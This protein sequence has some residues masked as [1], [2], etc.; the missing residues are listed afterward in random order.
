VRTF[1]GTGM[2]AAALVVGL[3]LTFPATTADAS[4]TGSSW[5]H[6][7]PGL[8][9][10]T[11][12]DAT[13]EAEVPQEGQTTSG[14]RATHSSGNYFMLARFGVPGGGRLEPGQYADGSIWVFD[15]VFADSGST[16]VVHEVSYGPDGA[17]TVLALDY[18]LDRFADDGVTLIRKVFG[19][20]RFHSDFQVGALA[21]DGLK[22]FG[23]VVTTVPAQRTI[24]IEN[25]G[26]RPVTPSG[27]RLDGSRATEFHIEDD[28]CTGATLLPGTTC[29]LDVVVVAT[30][31]GE[32]SA[33]VLVDSD[34]FAPTIGVAGVQAKAFTKTVTTAWVSPPAPLVTDIV[35][36]AATIEPPPYGGNLHFFLDGQRIGGQWLGWGNAVTAGPLALGMHTAYVFYEGGGDFAPSTSET[37]TFH[38]VEPTA[39]RLSANKTTTYVGQPPTLTA[40]VSGPADLSGGT[41]KLID[42]TNDATLGTLA[43]TLTTRSLTVTPALSAG[44][45]SILAEYSGTHEFASS[46]EMLGITVLADSGVALKSVTVTPGTFYPYR[47]GYRDTVSIGGVLDE[48]ATVSISIYAPSGRRVRL[49][50]LGTR[51]GS[52]HYTWNGR[53]ASGSMLASGK[54]RIV[55]RLRDT[56]G[57]SLSETSYVRVSAKRLYTYTRYYTK[58]ASAYAARQSSWIG[59]KFTL[60]AA[61]VYKKIA[62]QAYAWSTLVGGISIGAWDV[63]ECSFSCR[64]SPNYVSSWA[65]VGSAR[66]WYSKRLSVTYNRSGPYVRV[67]ASTSSTVGRGSVSQVRLK[68]VFGIL[69]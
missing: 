33:Q 65:G 57:H 3:L 13:F 12:A 26:S 37:V 35:S 10:L 21:G 60:P 17:L 19:A 66:K 40:S 47:D 62:F 45:H 43:V 44:V 8:M 64:W 55:Q 63:R 18:A 53:T 48:P 20:I 23:S 52:Y 51:T 25:T 42:T 61:T 1:A 15:S 41:L 9:T 22:D 69:K 38:V 29:S 67:F 27:L 34:S 24:T 30:A 7:I 49:E 28:T 11:S 59:W 39:T 50:N 5:Y 56:T 32:L 14:I 46:G 16:F 4:A 2:V 6:A 31:P 58:A 54:Y 36:F 68:V